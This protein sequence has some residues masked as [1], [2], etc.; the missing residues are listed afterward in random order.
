MAGLLAN[1]EEQVLCVKSREPKRKE[2]C[3]LIAKCQQ[4]NQG[5][6]D[7]SVIFFI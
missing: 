1:G 7:S 4:H 3:Q 5:Q 6:V 2:V